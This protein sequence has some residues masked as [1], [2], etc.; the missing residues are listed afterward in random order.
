MIGQETYELVRGVADVIPLGATDLKGKTIATQLYE[1]R[2]LRHE[3][4]PSP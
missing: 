1:L 4:S 2:A 3:G